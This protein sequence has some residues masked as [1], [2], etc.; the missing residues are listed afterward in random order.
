MIDQASL[1]ANNGDIK[2][3]AED[4]SSFTA[5]S[6]RVVFD[7]DILDVGVELGELSAQNTL[8]RHT[9]AFITDSTVAVTNGDLL[10]QATKDAQ[11]SAIAEAAELQGTTNADTDLLVDVS[12]D[13]TLATN[14]LEGDVAAYVNVSTVTTGWDAG[15]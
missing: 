12:L 13:G 5:L 15:G 7:L 10:I 1:I 14:A 11:F 3:A 9:N 8:K 2:L 4:N 6:P